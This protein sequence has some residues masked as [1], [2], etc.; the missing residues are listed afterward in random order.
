VVP[1]A[2]NLHF[3]TADAP[4]ADLGHCLSPK[5]MAG[6]AFRIAYLTAHHCTMI[7]YSAGSGTTAVPTV[8]GLRDRRSSLVVLEVAIIFLFLANAAALPAQSRCCGGDGEDGMAN[9]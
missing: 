8:G 5:P 3:A 2:L 4:V 1:L 7:Q 9:G 6:L